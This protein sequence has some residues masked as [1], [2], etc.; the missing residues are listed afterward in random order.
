[1]REIFKKVFLL[2][3]FGRRRKRGRL[4]LVAKLRAGNGVW[5]Y[6]ELNPPHDSIIRYHDTDVQVVIVRRQGY[7]IR[8]YVTRVYMDHTGT[9]ALIFEGQ[10]IRFLKFSP[11]T[12]KTLRRFSNV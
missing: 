11:Q 9:K 7:M 1:M 2:T 3:P 8:G 10:I 4:K 12:P 5:F 6:F